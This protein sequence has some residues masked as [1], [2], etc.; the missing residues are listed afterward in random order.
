MTTALSQA[1]PAILTR[2]NFA[3]SPN[4]RYGTC[5]RTSDED[6]TLEYWGL[7]SEQAWGQTIPGVAVDGATHTLPLDDGRILI[8]QRRGTDTSAVHEL[9]LLQFRDGGLCCERLGA[10]PSLVWG[11]LL[12]SP[13]SAHLGFVIA[14]NS[15]H[16]TIWRLSTLPPCIEPVIQIPGFLDGGVWL[17]SDASVLAVNQSCGSDRPNGIAIDLTKGSWERIWS[18]SLHSADRILLGSLQSRMA[19]VSTTVSGEERLGW[20]TLGDPTVHFPEILHRPGYERRALAL[21]DRGERL[22]VHEVAGAVSRLLVYT[23]AED[24][25]LPLAGP[26]GRITSPACWTGNL[27]RCGFS[28]PTQPSTLATVR[29]EPEPRTQWSAE[30]FPKWSPRWSPKWS[31]SRDHHG[32][33][34]FAAPQAELV[35]LEGPAG[36]IEA[37][38]Y[39]GSDWRTCQHLVVALHGGPLSSWRFKFEPLFY[40]LATEGV[41]VVAPNYRG[42]TGYGEEHLRAVIGN[43]G[44]PDLDDVLALGRDLEQERA[45]RQLPRPVILGVSYGAFLAL[46]AACHEPQLWSACV[47]LAPFLSGPCFHDGAN[48]AVRRRIEQLGGLRPIEGASGPRDVL[49]ACAA[50]SAPLLLMH[51]VEDQTI[52][53]AQSRTLRRR[54][55][56]LGKTEGVDIEYVEINSGH[57]EL[58]EQ[59]VLNQRVARFCLARSELDRNRHIGA[60]YGRSTEP[61]PAVLGSGTSNPLTTTRDNHG[62][63]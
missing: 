29:L 28:A 31:L 17:D 37:I 11:Y 35:D 63:L 49:R 45:S 22:L 51:G 7:A 13:S 3:F 2:S 53:I 42:S 41:A 55:L 40:C 1:A 52:P 30:W 23:P 39:G 4:G 56:E 48:V 33:G 58:I 54:L 19:V 32:E 6:M 20:A 26:P 47:A 21:D 16:S 8:F 12:P 14:L 46:L 61:L 62:Q 5:L 57:D 38:V 9:A 15:E 25:L 18:R 34:H 50:L 24:R 43:W 27:I 10:I 36:P 44:G 60:P 59:S